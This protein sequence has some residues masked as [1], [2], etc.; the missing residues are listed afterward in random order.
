MSHQVGDSWGVKK[1]RRVQQIDGCFFGRTRY[2]GFIFQKVVDLVNL[3]GGI[4]GL[5]IVSFGRFF[6]GLNPQPPQLRVT[7]KGT[8]THTQK[9]TR[10]L[11]LAV[12]LLRQVAI[13][14][15]Q[16]GRHGKHGCKAQQT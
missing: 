12:H 2:A 10:R 3:F 4:Y 16:N 1:V 11:F 8:H 13:A 6:S 7:D 15:H 9:N 5:D 14:A